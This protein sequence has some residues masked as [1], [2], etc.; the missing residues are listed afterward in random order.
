MQSSQRPHR[1]GNDNSSKH[2]HLRAPDGIQLEAELDSGCDLAGLQWLPLA[3]RIADVE[4]ARASVEDDS[5][6]LMMGDAI[7][8]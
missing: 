7:E 1:T 2:F 6:A 4:K 8:V 5:I 3:V